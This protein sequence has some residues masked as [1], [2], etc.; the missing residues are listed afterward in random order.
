[1]RVLHFVMI[2][3]A[4]VAGIS[5][6][7][8]VHGQVDKTDAEGRALLDRMCSSCHSLA[9]TLR[10]RYDKARWTEVVE[11][12]LSRGAQGTDSEVRAVIDFL[13]TRYGPTTQPA[14]STG[15][16]PALTAPAS[17]ADPA[18]SVAPRDQSNTQVPFERILN[19]D[20]DPGNWLTYH[21][22]YASQSYSRLSQITAANIKNLE[23]AWAF[24]VRWLEGPFEARPLVVDGVLY[25]VQGNDVVALDAT[26]GRIF[27]NLSVHS[28]A[29]GQILWCQ[30]RSGDSRRH[31]VHCD[32]R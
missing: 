8:Q 30:P 25:T 17:N 13:A 26:S 5:A 4:M 7:D 31:R 14:A 15:D 23:L 19:A 6:Q 18:Q 16:A 3:A 9:D 32:R 29:G 10:A 20:K 28:V 22:T 11:D 21:G 2:A 27:W 12:M 1:M 24:Q